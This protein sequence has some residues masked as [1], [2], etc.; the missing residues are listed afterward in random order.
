MNSAAAIGPTHSQVAASIAPRQA[1]GPVYDARLST[2]RC[3][4]ERLVT[5]AAAT[6]A[7]AT[8]A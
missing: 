6:R 7:T 4:L 2:F 1:G 8:F 3:P 5:I